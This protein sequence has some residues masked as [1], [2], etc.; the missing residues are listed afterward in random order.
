M[1]R[2]YW[3]I[4]LAILG[5]SLAATAWLYPGLP[6]SIPTHWDLA[7]KVD[8][9]GGKWT[10]FLL[11]AMMPAVLALF[12]FLPALS[13]RHFEVDSFRSVYLYVMALVFG[14]FAFMQ[15]ILLYAVARDVRGGG[16]FDIGRVFLAGLCLF[17]GLIGRVMGKIRRN[18]YIGVRLPWTLASERVWNDTHRLAAWV[19]VAVGAAGFILTIAG[20]PTWLA[21][22]ILIG[23]VSVLPLYAF[24]HYKALERTGQLEP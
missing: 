8:G 17:L 9:R 19:M 5:V 3:I 13:P 6:D 11:P 10:I 14:L 24:L 18:F 16:T 15:G 7:G 12:Y 21:I 23:S 22:V 2:G 1:T 20:A 4:T